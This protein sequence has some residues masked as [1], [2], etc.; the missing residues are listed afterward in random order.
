M[1]MCKK[2]KDEPIIIVVEINTQASKFPRTL[3]YLCHICEIVGYKLTNYPKFAKMKTMFK[4]KSGK[5][6]GSKPLVEV[7]VVKCLN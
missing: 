2:N 6:I 3:N 1:E 4:D 7:K 5:T